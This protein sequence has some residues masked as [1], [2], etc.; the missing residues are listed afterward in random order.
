MDNYENRHSYDE[1]LGRLDE[2]TKSL[3]VTMDEIKTKL[4]LSYVTQDEFKPIKL[5]VYGVT[6]LVGVAVF[7]AVISLVVHHS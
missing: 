1:L 4:A 7:G 6:G 5:L 2:R 3:I